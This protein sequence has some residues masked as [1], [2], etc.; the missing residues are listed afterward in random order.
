MYV[1]YQGV[2]EPVPYNQI[3]A[4]GI[5]Y[6]EHRTSAWDILK[7]YGSK[8]NVLMDKLPKQEYLS[9]LWQSKLAISPFGMGEVCYRDFELM[10]FGTLMIKPDMSKVKTFP[11]PYISGD[12]YI[13]VKHDWSDLME[14]VEDILNNY[15]LYSDISQTLEKSLRIFIQ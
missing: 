4:P 12:T 1:I 14:K 3:V 7:K 15:N 8:Y 5:Q 9:K 2:H 13:P 6:T 10:Q 11:N